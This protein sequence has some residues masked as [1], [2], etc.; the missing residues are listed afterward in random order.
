M[1]RIAVFGAGGFGREVLMLI[2]QINRVEKKW[3]FIGFFDDGHEKGT[4]VNGYEVL[5]GIEDLK[6]VKDSISLVLGVGSPKVKKDVLVQLNQNTMLSYPTLIHPNVEIGENYKMGNGCII[7]AG[8]ILTENFELGDFVTLNLCCTVGHDAVIKNYCSFMP[9]VNISGETFFSEGV[10]VG[11]SATIINQKK[12]GEWVTVG[13]GAVII[14]DV[15]NKV[16]VVGNPGRVL[17]I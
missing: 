16:T 15:P 1:N 7:T 6:M 3:D 11:T 13:A 4:L 9:N 5:G 14:R 2:N 8:C 12:I 10:Y 17:N